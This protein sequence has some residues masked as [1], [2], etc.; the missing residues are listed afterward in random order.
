[1]FYIVSVVYLIYLVIPLVQ[2]V[3]EA[4]AVQQ[5]RFLIVHRN[6]NQI[7]LNTSF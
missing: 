2:W 3:Q 5:R 7:I 6:H 1:M 4:Q